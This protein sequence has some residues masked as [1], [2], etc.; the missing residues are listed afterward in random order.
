M[1]CSLYKFIQPILSLGR[2]APVKR[3]HHHVERYNEQQVSHFVEFILSPS[4]TADLP[5]GIR[6]MKMATGEV[7][8]VPNT[9]R[10]TIS[11]RII[12]QYQN[13]CFETTNGEF[14]PL[15]FTSLMGILNACPA[16][17]RKSMA[18]ID[19]Y[20]ANGSTAFDSLAKICDE[21]SFYG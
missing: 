16:S 12:R 9:C 11:T 17:T 21:L 7:I 18:G 20:S 8:E 15:G 3:A 13:Y 5:F 1:C 14:Q 4:I 6:K 2:G 19:E 10:N